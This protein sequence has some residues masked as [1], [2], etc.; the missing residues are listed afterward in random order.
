MQYLF[1]Y[2]GLALGRAH[3]NSNFGAQPLFRQ[4]LPTFFLKGDARHMFAWAQGSKNCVYVLYVM[5]TFWGRN[6]RR[7]L[8][9]PMT[10]SFQLG[11]YRTFLISPGLTGFKSW[12]TRL[13]RGSSHRDRR[14]STLPN[15][16]ESYSS[17]PCGESLMRVAS[18]KERGSGH[19][20]KKT[21]LV[22][23]FQSV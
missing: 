22:F 10:S 3:T 15:Q 16:E 9:R 14:N 1:V 11:T 17:F 20:V 8:E 23:S 6:L 18:L 21:K 2:C 7:V 5:C 12:C 13:P 19:R 4:F